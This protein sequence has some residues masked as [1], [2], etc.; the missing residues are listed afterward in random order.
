[1]IQYFIVVYGLVVI[2]KAPM[3]RVFSMT[4]DVKHYFVVE[5]FLCD[6]LAFDGLEWE[7]ERFDLHNVLVLI[8]MIGLV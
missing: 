5:G 4:L 7:I 3:T 1:M 8:E 6:E 2:P